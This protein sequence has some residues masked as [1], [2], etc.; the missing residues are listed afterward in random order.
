MFGGLG[1]YLF[2]DHNTTRILAVFLSIV[3]PPPYP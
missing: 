1:S 3:S 2:A